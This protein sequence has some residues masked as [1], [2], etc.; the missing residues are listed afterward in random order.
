MTLG[1]ILTLV[2][3]CAQQEA[4]PPVM[5]LD[6]EGGLFGGGRLDPFPSFLHVGPD[7]HLAVEA[8]PWPVPDGGTPVPVDRLAW[9][10]GFSP[11]QP[12]VA[13]LDEVDPSRLPGWR[14][15]T[16]GGVRLWDLTAG[17][18]LPVMAEID[19]S[20]EATDPMLIVRP[21]V[22]L[23]AGHTVAVVV[24]ADTARRP[25]AFQA[26]IDDP[27]AA[28]WGPHVVDLLARLEALGEPTD[29]LA[30]AWDFPIGD[31]TA[32]VRS[33]VAQV[34]PPNAWR[35]DEVLDRD[36]GSAGLLPEVW[37]TAT[38]AYAVQDFLVDDEWLDLRPDGSVAQTGTAEAYLYVSIPNAVADAPA[39]SVPVWIFG[40]GMF[41]DPEAYL[42]ESPDDDEVVRL[43][44]E[45]GAILV[46]TYWRGLSSPD[47]A[48]AIESTADFGQ[49]GILPDRTVQAHAN[50]RTLVRMLKSG[51]LLQ[52]PVFRG[53]SGQALADPGHLAYYGISM[54]AIQG[55]ILMA[56]DEQVEAAALHVGGG[57][58]M[59]ALERGN[60]WLALETLFRI[61]VIDPNERQQV[62]ALG[63][64]WMDPVDPMSWTE[65]LAAIDRPVLY[66]ESRGDNYVHNLASRALIRSIG[67]P[68]ARPAVDPSWGIP[69]VDLPLPPG[70]TVMV[71][72]DPEVGEQPDTNRPAD[73][74]G[75]HGDPRLWD[76]T[77]HQILDFLEQ[78]RLGQVNHWCGDGF[79]SASNQGQ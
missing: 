69:A 76:G 15:E 25:E 12:I 50:V 43:A 79:C 6:P 32:P 40:H 73:D 48:L 70:S 30:V 5:P 39:G 19:A 33:A 14:E 47:I 20:P 34:D 16:T 8:D 65:D 28:A 26:V 61:K 52:D 77:R 37:R 58:V 18:A 59:T 38:G 75:A 66:H 46:A 49:Y 22:A 3:G 41:G 35:F 71:Q 11:A 56:H 23:P 63:Q 4:D 1:V 10:T 78:G 36:A 55:A 24:D 27:R 44:E 51:E 45:A 9:R 53:R 62:L 64:L 67:V 7:G 13:H 60:P 17:R 72:L 54:G 42:A 21:M 31:A 57:M 68:I 29:G 74:T 2:Q